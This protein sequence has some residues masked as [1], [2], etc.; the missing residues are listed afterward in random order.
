[1][2]HQEEASEGSLPSTIVVLENVQEAV[3][4]C[5]LIMLVENI[6]GLSE[7]DGDFSVEMIPEIHAAAVTFTGNIAAG[8]FAEKLNQHHRAKQQNITARC[9]EQTK[10][11]RA[12]NIPPHTHSDY[13]TLYFENKK[14]GGAE[15][16]DVQ[17][18][19]EEDAA[20]ITFKDH[21]DVSNVLAKQ[22][23]LNRTPISVYPYYPSLGT[24]LYG[25]EE[26]Q[27]KKPDPVTVPLDPYIWYYLQRKD[28]LIEAVNREMAKCN[29][30]PTWPKPYNEN[31]K[32]TLSPS[33]TLSEKKRLVSLLI[34]TW[35]E[36]VSTAFSRCISKYRAAK[37]Q[38]SAE[39]WEAIRNSF[40]PD[41]VVVIPCIS[42]DLLV[43]VG[44][45]GV[46][47]NAEQELKL[48]LEKA[49]REIER[50]K[51]RT[52]EMVIMGP[53]E[54]AILQST[55][56]EEKVRRDFPALQIT[57]D[58]VQKIV[59]LCGMP[60]EVYKV[61]GEILDN[62]R[63]IAKKMVNIHP[64]IFKF[65][66]R[67][68][69]ETLSQ[70]LFMSRQINAF[71]ELGREAVILKG[72]APEDLLKAEE[73][74]KEELDHKSIALEDKSIL[75]KEEWK[76]LT[77]Y[78]CSNEAL[79]VTEEESQVVIAGFSQAVAKAFEDLYNF[80]DENTQVRKVIGRKPMAVIMFFEKEKTTVWGDLQTKGVKVDFSTERKNRVI[81][82][83]GPRREVLKGVTLVE[84]ILS[85][86]HYRRVVI[87]EPGAKS[88]FKEREHYFAATAK[89][90][91]KC[92]IRLEDQSEE[93]QEEEQE[94]RNRGKHCRQVTIGGV[95]VS[96]IKG[97]LCAHPVDV[98]VNAS[99][100]DLKHIGGLADALLRAAG[101]ELQQECDELVKKNGSLQ[102][103]CA[104]I[105]GAG[106]LPCKNV[107]HAV[108]PR[109][110]KEE[111]EKCVFL[112]RKT[113][114]KSLQLAETYN[115]R[116]IAVPA[117]SAGVFGFPLELCTYSIV[118][119]I[120]ETLEQ[121]MGD[122][123]L[124]EVH[125]MDIS[126][127]NVDAFSKALRE[128][129]A[130]DSA[131]YV[132][133]Y[134]TRTVYLPRKKKCSQNS[135]NFPLLTT[136][137]GLDIILKKGS[138][139]GATTDVVVISVA[140]DLNL[141]KGLLAKTLLSKAGPMLQSS[142][143]EEGLKE[144][145]M[146]GSV[147]KTK[148]YNLDCSVVLHAVLPAWSQ[149]N[150]SSKVFG[151]IVTKCLEIAEELSLKS[152]TFPAMGT[153]VLR[154]PGS[155]VAKILFD[156]VFEYSGKKGLSS[157]EEVHFLLHPKDVTNIEEFS[158]ELQN[159]SGNVKLP[160]I[161]PDKAS[162]GTDVSS[163][164]SSLAGNGY[165]MRVGSVVFQVEKGDITSEKGDVIV[166][167]T[168]QTFSLKTGVSRAIL[169]SA[170]K[171][172]EDE[173]AQLASQSNKSYI[174]TQAGNLSCK[175]IIHCV[176]QDDIKAIVSRV[177]KECELQQ[178]TSVAF[179]AIGT[180]EAGRD[181]AIVADNM[182][183]AVT[184]FARTY[185]APSV[186]TVKV[187]IFQPH[188][189]DVFHR[190][191]KKRENPAKTTGRSLL[192]RIM[193]FC[194]PERRSPKEKAKTQPIFSKKIEMAVMQI[195]GENQKK[196]EEAENWL[197]SAI[198]KEQH[199]MEIK[200]ESVIHFGEVEHE[201][202]QKLQNVLKIAL[203]VDGTSIHISGVEKDV[204]I[205]HSSVQKMI[206]AVKAAKQEEIKAELLQNLIQ[207]KYL[208]N[209]LYVPFSSLT[210]MYLEEAFRN[211][212][213]VI[214]VMVDEKKY[215]ADID[216][217]CI[218][219]DQGRSRPIIRIDKSEDQESV[220]LP[221][222]WDDMQNQRLRIV[223]LKPETKEYKDVQ[224]K[225]QKSCLSY[226]I[227][228]IE[229][230]Q[231]PYFWKTYQ[232]KKRE[233]DNKNGNRNN[234]KH[235][236]HGTS[237]DSVTLINNYGFNRSYA[238]TNGANYGNGT[239]FAVN[240]N[241][242]ASDSFSRPDAFGKKHMYLARVLVGEYSQGSRGSITPAAKN[243]SNSVDLF[244]SSTDNM[245]NPSMFIIFNDIQAYP[246]YLITFTR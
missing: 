73:T 199:S 232:I 81:S 238:G 123:S 69:N 128:V 113:V 210:N 141:S 154:Y 60:E 228:K 217:R 174:T 191:M 155:V 35:N 193:T 96:V 40:S 161:S 189:L 215:T 211:K 243:A 3:K 84:D 32:V 111:A 8:K 29:C 222:T 83:S 149:R 182:I 67:V 45:E 233:M 129:F 201:E 157:L 109:W 142:L 1:E 110:R 98:V 234:E 82:L 195:C 75:Q 2:P 242:S 86:L 172:V 190:S 100:E 48:L 107:I 104:V 90:D 85:G 150:T 184:D 237:K 244:D 223:E 185:S 208:K 160:K 92:L 64:Y 70:S 62:T 132:P 170:G 164:V 18:L 79:T 61:K 153:G 57:Y 108:G 131:S 36:N 10:S 163:A 94:W 68:D 147:L 103:G 58:H 180:G 186:R 175:K 16:E 218:L 80:I 112:L 6:S 76:M 133:P 44:E 89:Q 221:A 137:E 146:E 116:S 241:Y 138:I 183:D 181:P 229:R 169:S 212:Q 140:P 51:Q 115:H 74:I 231:N 167:I 93:Q 125:L 24:A 219:D 7:D 230:I 66:E 165:E 226:K 197:K 34:K 176:A 14:N 56:L 28:G 15:V 202:L 50:E 246:E 33:A 38:V 192:S 235:L 168:N 119:S 224:E 171:A 130:D 87:R 127:N 188:L 209:D 52:E 162:K 13:I 25:K 225:F 159:R 39:V 106:K 126:Q 214:S 97:N 43:V 198:L 101:P 5:M 78:N 240:A 156:K 177:L 124:K 166:N 220:A 173:C 194:G 77:K 17:Q 187:V 117:V 11:V 245:Q 114:K 151:D 207:W 122:S 23:S 22:H 105:T 65:L 121:S 42:K 91:F 54:Y 47:K 236:F 135:K 204:W 216:T 139:E 206:H 72:W 95:V 19:P 27:I 99:N 179:P 152:I 145:P 71:Y 4:D 120:R 12:E 227:E 203:S 213:K 26:P 200:D 53:G 136:E 144:Q 239:Y 196:V 143:R 63:K 37:Y 178:Y 31:P 205:A 41:E 46:V 148:G 55:G 9:L 20:I 134:R 88:Y 21:K 118:S 102:P 30:V 158:R 49:T 59:N